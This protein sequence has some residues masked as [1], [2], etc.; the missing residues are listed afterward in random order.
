MS[1]LSRR[2]ARR[3]L[4]ALALLTTSFSLAQPVGEPAHPWEGWE[5]PAAAVPVPNAFDVIGPDG[6]DDFGTPTEG[7][8]QA[9]SR[10]DL[11]VVVE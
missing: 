2:G 10:G 11:V 9:D 6:V 4:A 3:H 1:V 8:V 5:P 7:P